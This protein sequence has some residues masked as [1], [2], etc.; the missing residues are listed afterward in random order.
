MLAVAMNWEMIRTLTPRQW[1]VGLFVVALVATCVGVWSIF[2]LR[3]WFREDSGRADDNLKMLTQFRD[4][5][6]QGGISADEYRLIKSRLVT[7]HGPQ[8]NAGQ[9]AETSAKTAAGR[10][11]TNELDG[12]HDGTDAESRSSDKPPTME[13]D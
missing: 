13:A 7:G 3:A 4:L 2:Q 6:R 1:A 8:S 5:H 11:S 12:P 9:G 10:P